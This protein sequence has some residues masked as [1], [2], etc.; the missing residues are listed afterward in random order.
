MREWDRNDIYISN[1]GSGPLRARILCATPKTVTMERW[2]K[3]GLVRTRF[4]LPASYLLSPNCGWVKQQ[5]AA[6]NL[7]KP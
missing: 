7:D 2:H 5:S 4:T 6:L 1:N 3:N